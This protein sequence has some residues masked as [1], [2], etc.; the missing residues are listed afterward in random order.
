MDRESDGFRY[1]R[2]IFDVGGTL[3][4]IHDPRPFQEF[5]VQAGL[6][7]G[8][9]DTRRLHRRLI[10]TLRLVTFLGGAA[11]LIFGLWGLRVAS[12]LAVA[13][14]VAASIAFVALV[15]WHDRVLRARD[16]AAMLVRWLGS[17]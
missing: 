5:L 11:A 1:D 2:V 13:G 16:R 17:D 12:P 15:F 14:G 10:S 7:A 6:P 3:L 8:Q 9:T 4:G